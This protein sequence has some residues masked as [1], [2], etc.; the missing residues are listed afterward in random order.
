MPPKSRT[1]FETIR[2][3][4]YA[5]YKRKVLGSY[6]T[7]HPITGNYVEGFNYKQHFQKELLDLIYEVGTSNG[8]T[9]YATGVIVRSKSGMPRSNYQWAHRGTIGWKL[10]EVRN[11]CEVFG[12]GVK[13]TKPQAMGDKRYSVETEGINREFLVLRSSNYPKFF[14]SMRKDNLYEFTVNFQEDAHIRLLDSSRK[15]WNHY[16]HFLKDIWRWY[17]IRY[18][19]KK[20]LPFDLKKM[21]ALFVLKFEANETLHRSKVGFKQDDATWND[22]EQEEDQEEGLGFEITDE[23]IDEWLPEIDWEE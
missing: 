21:E 18:S 10:W 11:I 7:R 12:I 23:D 9:K 4:K 6:D 20:K 14:V 5:D 15:K 8:F 13:F 16:F 22:E 2:R 19:G 3:K 1:A 17:F